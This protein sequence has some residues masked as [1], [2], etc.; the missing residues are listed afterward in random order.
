MVALTEKAQET[1]SRL[2]ANA[3][4]GTNGLRIMVDTGGCSGLRYSLGLEKSACEGDRVYEF[5]AIRVYVDPRSLPIV[6]G[7]RVDF[8]ES[9]EGSG[10]VFDNPNA[11]DVCSCGKSFSG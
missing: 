1:L 5:G 11:K 8:V 6:D 10:F 9:I 2:L 3:E 4:P 7:M